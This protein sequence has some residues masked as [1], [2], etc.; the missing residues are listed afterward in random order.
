[1]KAIIMAGG[2]GSRL[3]PLTCDCPK[4]M[5]RLM[6]KPLMEHAIRLLQK[7]GINEIGATLGY[8][9]DA[10]MDYFGDGEALGASLRY[11]IEKVPLGTAGSVRQA[12]DFLDERFIVLSGDGVTDFDLGEAVRFHE[13]RGALATLVLVK[14]GAPQE[15]GMVVTDPD[16]LIRA[17]HEKPGRSDIY[18]DRINTGIYIL[19]P[20]ILD[21]IPADKPFDFGHDLFPALVKEGLPVY[22]CTASGYW[23]DVGDVG[24][25]LRV[26]ADA[27]DGRIHLDGLAPAVEDALLEPGC[28]LEAP[29]FVASGA[30]IAPGARVGA[31]S[32]IGEGC[33]IAPGVSIK[34]S[35]LFPGARVEPGAQL[36]GCV[37]GA[38]AVIGEGA[39][40]YEESVVG[41]SSRVGARAVLPPGVKLWPQ[42]ALPEGERPDANI[43]WGSRREQ[44]FVAGALLL[45][46]P[47]QA[48]RAAQSC[49][50]ELKPR[51]LLIGR[52]A[53]SVADAMWHAAAAGAMAQ[54]A[55]V[56]DA[57]ICTLPQLR[58]AMRSLHSDAALLV[59]EDRLI[60][61]LA[62]GARLPERIQRAILKLF[63]RG[64]FCG[65]FSGI[66]RPMQSA[67]ATDAA[68]VADVA[69]EFQADPACAPG[70]ALFAQD[71]RLLELA[72]RTL[73]RAGLRVR[74]A[75][76]ADERTPEPGELAIELCPGGEQA[77]L[78]DEHGALTEVERQLACAWIALE[79]GE[80][81][82]ILPLHATRAVET[83]ALRRGAHAL[84]LPGEH[85]L[86]MAEA[87]EKAPAQFAIHFDG[88]R[89][90]L[91]FLSLLTERGLSLEQWRRQMPTAY[92]SA[93]AV[94]IPFAESG[95][96]LHAL[97]ESAPGAE[98]GGGVRLPR[99]EGWAWLT[100]DDAGAGLHIVAESANM[101]AAQELCDFYDRE[102]A[103]LMGTERGAN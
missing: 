88:L 71:A 31:Y 72:E 13:S 41:S 90:A 92:R 67:G 68:Y 23:C 51:E 25:Y 49:V 28:M 62:N 44:R 39:Q 96:L 24:A 56:V 29:V 70:I 60:P 2:E 78:S 97:A 94:Q 30:H 100:P 69:T 22:G 36:R 27:M 82:L 77:I 57:G 58:H 81:R 102:L 101:E 50:A 10:I 46:S 74:G 85:A 93:R 32:V 42:K 99:E 9:P 55:Q 17:F 21:R 5:L 4:P 48:A 18:S 79:R 35:I 33:F 53:S 84:Y 73:G 3:R 37:V 34:R 61:L 16:G 59:E 103:R 26:H 91:A 45:E 40:L 15:Y 47:A 20:D 8:Q 12:K 7:Y 43:V 64:D 95:R 65:P 75:W 87:A 66:T 52:S 89:F 63:E 76:S 19:E 54:S 6:G 38:N 14:S 83:L 98:M 80:P 86:W 11:Y 1:M